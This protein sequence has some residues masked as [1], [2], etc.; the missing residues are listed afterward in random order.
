MAIQ[1]LWQSEVSGELVRQ[2]TSLLGEVFVIMWKGNVIVDTSWLLTTGSSGLSQLAASSETIIQGLLNPDEKDIQVRLLKKG[3][4]FSQAVWLALTEVPMGQVRTYS[5]LAMELHSGPRAIAQA[6]RM[7][8][9]P[10]IIPCHRVVSKSGVGGFMGQ[11]L[12]SWV[13]LKQR[14]LN[15][16]RKIARRS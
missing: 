9:Y 12:G 5:D 11:R 14:L 13:D 7:N 6:C 15:Y 4:A 10:G 1:I 8:P 3:S 16:E 2:E